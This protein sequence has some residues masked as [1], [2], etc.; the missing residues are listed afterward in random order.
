MAATAAHAE[1]W[2]GMPQ[3]E[4][5]AGQVA[6]LVGV[7]ITTLRT[8]DRR[9]GLGPQSH[10]AGKHR[11]YGPSDVDRIVEMQRLTA[12]GVPPAEAAAW[13]LDR[14]KPAA[15]RDG[16]GH[17][18]AVGRSGPAV[19]G[20]TR[21]AMRLD[22]NQ[23]RRLVAEAIAA[24]GVIHAWTDLLAPALIHI[25]RKHAATQAIVE[26]EHLLSAEISFA[27]A[28]V[29]RPDTSARVLLACADEEQHSLALEALAAALAEQGIA[30]RLLG[31]R[32]PPSALRDA[33]H[34]AGPDIVVVWSQ[35][36]ETADPRQL[37]PLL[38]A[39]PAVKLVVAAGP[40][41]D[42]AKVPDGVLRPATLDEATTAIA[43]SRS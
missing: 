15:H 30:A 13:V 16:G 20:L 26:V 21:A 28:G 31:A 22:A 3:D 27:L 17:S 5:T 8:W 25:G 19:R 32:V 33:V 1:G 39:R 38:V 4:L 6:Q 43:G 37:E 36:S 11:R 14:R 12:Q 23:M 41:W 34:R 24:N 40:G 10:Q 29:A 9:Y 42:T 35:T 7:A 2:E 18:V